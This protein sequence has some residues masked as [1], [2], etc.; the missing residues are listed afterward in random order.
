V[1]GRGQSSGIPGGNGKFTMVFS[2]EVSTRI[3]RDLGEIEEIRGVWSAWNRQPNS[4]IDFYLTVLRCGP[5]VVRPH[6]IVLNRGGLP[7]ALLIGRIEDTRFELKMG[8][9]TVFRPAARTLTF[10]NGGL[11]G[12]NRLRIARPWSTL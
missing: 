1:K 4:D 5:E 7:N 8:Y 2:P 11:L 10:V 6:I 9:R 3:V 12:T